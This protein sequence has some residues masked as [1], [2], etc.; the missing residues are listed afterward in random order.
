MLTTCSIFSRGRVKKDGRGRWA[1]T[2]NA[3]DDR[4]IYGNYN[5]G[6]ANNKD[7]NVGG[8]N[9]LV[10]RDAAPAALLLFHRQERREHRRQ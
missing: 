4:T 6:D 10:P 7:D 8:T 9:G 2:S 5:S 3:N 1:P